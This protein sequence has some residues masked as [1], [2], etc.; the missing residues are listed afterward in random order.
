MLKHVDSPYH[1][2]QAFYLSHIAS[3]H[4]TSETDK[5]LVLDSDTPIFGD[6]KGV[7]GCTKAVGVYHVITQNRPKIAT[8]LGPC[9]TTMPTS[10]R[11]GTSIDKPS[12]RFE[13]GVS[14]CL[15]T[16]MCT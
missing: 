15:L 7:L 8:Y 2:E 3:L 12:H 1:N 9:G 4:W 14:L 16:P 5:V 13:R 11:L 10:Q 6:D